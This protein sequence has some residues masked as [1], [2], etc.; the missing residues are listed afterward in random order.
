MDWKHSDGSTTVL[1]SSAQDE[2][3]LLGE[4]AVDIGLVVDG[5]RIDD[6]AID[7]CIGIGP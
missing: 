5:Q 1:P 6:E 3:G 4:E 7:A 2:F